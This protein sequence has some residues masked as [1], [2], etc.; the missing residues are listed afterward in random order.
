[1]DVL[2]PLWA[3]GIRSARLI[4]DNELGATLAKAAGEQGMVLE[5]SPLL[6]DGSPAET[7]LIIVT[8]TAGEALSTQ[9][10][11]CLDL[12]NV[13]VVAPVTDWH[14]RNRPLFLISIPKAGTHLLYKLAEAFGY[15]TGIEFT[16]WPSPGHWYCI[17]YSNSHT[18]ARDFFIDTVRRSKFGN[19]HHPFMRSPAVFIYRNPLDILVS[20]ANY[21]HLDG[22]T[23][24]AGY[25]SSLSFPERLRRLVDDPWLLGSIRDRIGNFAAWLDCPNVA[26]VSFEELVGADGG[27]DSEIQESVIWSLQL[28]LQVP[29]DPAD[30]GCKVF[31]RDSQT[32]REGQIG[33]YGKAVTEE[34]YRIFKKL[35]QDFMTAFGYD[36]ATL[37]HAV[38]PPKR[39]EEFR[40]RPLRIS[41]V[42]FAGMPLT[43][44]PDYLGCNLVRF[45]GRFYA[46]P[47][48]LGPI[49]I[50]QLPDTALSL[51]PQAD[52]LLDLKYSLALGVTAVGEI[53][54]WID[55]ELASAV[56]H[57]MQ[58]GTVNQPQNDKLSIH[59]LD[60]P[61]RW[62]NPAEPALMGDYRGF[63]LI[64]Y[65]GEVWAAAIAAG[66]LDL[67]DAETVKHWLADG[68]LQRAAT[69]DGARANV[70]RHAVEAAMASIAQ[71]VSL[72]VPESGD[73]PRLLE[74]DYR[75]F[76]LSPTRDRS[77][78][79]QMAA[80]PVDFADAA[81]AQASAG[82][83]STDARSD[84]RWSA[85]GSGP[86][87]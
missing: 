57:A 9:L 73:E 11:S 55:N 22:K 12:A 15:G 75:G 45:I 87:A 76:N 62:S 1:M 10:L 47:I 13:V 18:S 17:E 42:D 16:D 50:A 39:A 4:G 8:E 24:F 60:R 6:N 67:T 65:A 44:E 14:F 74:E 37:E 86:A 69:I 82:G 40:R 21:Y 43:V 27:G 70:D 46:V 59:V 41:A 80:G 30:Y 20:E 5:R 26:P 53:R 58:E 25:L 3:E 68:R 7:Q 66:P 36:G 83:G 34:A 84:R 63:N 38:F 61:K 71:R 85:G 54:G 81:A 49:D 56:F 77:G 23:A 29:G 72:I 2:R 51:L 19:R 33:S 35:P 64:A 31:S 78:P 48:S 32:F 28:K 52:K 79:R